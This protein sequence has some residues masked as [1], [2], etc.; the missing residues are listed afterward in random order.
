MRL[1]RKNETVCI[2]LES[3]K[4]AL[5]AYDALSLRPRV[6]TVQREGDYAI[7]SIDFPPMASQ[8]RWIYAIGGQWLG[9]KQGRIH[10]QIPTDALESTI[11]LFKTAWVQFKVV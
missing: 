11:S 9:S 3:S 4:L 7:L 2:P 1:I 5:L 6:A 8:V 10:W